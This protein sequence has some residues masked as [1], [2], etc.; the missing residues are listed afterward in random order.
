MSHDW[1]DELDHAIADGVSEIV[2]LRRHLHMNPEV[3]GEEQATSLYLYQLLGNDGFEVR[4]GPEGRGVIADL[5]GGEAAAA[6]WLALRADIDALRIHDTKSVEYCSQCDGVMHACGHDA[7][8]AVIWGALRAVRQLQQA[9]KLPWAMHVR[10]V[11]QPSEET[12]QGAQEMIIAGALE[13]VTS[14]LA[15]HVDPSRDIGHIGLRAGVL[16]ASCDE[17]TICIRG[18]GGHAARPHE[19]SD[20]ISAAAQLINSLYLNISRATDSQDAVVITIGQIQAG[21]NANVIPEE[22]ILRGS[23]RTLNR[24]I[25]Q[26]TMDHIRRMADGLGQT[27]ET[28]IEVHYGIG[29][30]S[31]VNDDR[32]IEMLRMAAS[33]VVGARGVDEIP[34]A[35][36]GSED[37]A[38]YL[39]H[40]P[41]AM[42]RLGCRSELA[43]GAP[44]HTPT[45]DVDERALPIGARVLAR[46]LILQA[47][48]KRVAGNT[49]PNYQI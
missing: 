23:I 37:F 27:T 49:V 8:T 15:V 33:E 39:D 17:M 13:Q 1:R 16:T 45:F 7:H 25:R 35:S 36:M 48:P 14:I 10:G 30:G 24:A 19:T 46:A 11:F 5:P 22:V 47:D 31:V 38:F 34:R 26:Q 32:L 21:D 9:G 44:L 29:S 40:V 20:P 3:S 2:A 12:C 41:G 4:L 6:G 18:R 42:L 28:E 43:G